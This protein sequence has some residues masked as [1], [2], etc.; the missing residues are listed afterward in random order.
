MNSQFEEKGKIFT[1]VISK[2]PL[3]VTIQTITHRIHGELYVRPGERLKDELNTSEEFLAVTNA[4]IYDAESR[5]LYR[6]G[7]LTLS[8]RQI[9][10][11]IP[12]DE[13][14]S[15]SVKDVGDNG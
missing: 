8:L 10:W 6:C 2:T 14:N 5:E 15:H 13:L 12:D 7:F 11:L 9:V 1:N 3:Q 4:T